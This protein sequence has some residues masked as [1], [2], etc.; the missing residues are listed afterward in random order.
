MQFIGV[1]AAQEIYTHNTAATWL[2]KKDPNNNNNRH[3][4]M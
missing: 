4:N 1:T 2:P 3:A